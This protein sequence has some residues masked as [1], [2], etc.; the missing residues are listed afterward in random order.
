[1][2][3]K[4]IFLDFYGTLVHEDDDIIPVIC[5]EIRLSST[6]PESSVT[7][8]AAYWWKSFSALMTGSIGTAFE[9]QRALS[10]KS[11]IETVEYFD[12]RANA[13]AIIEPQFAHWANPLL[14]ED[15]QP[16][17][18]AFADR[19]RY[20]LSNIDTADVNAAIA[21]HQLDITAVLTSEDVRAYKPNPRLFEEALE[22]YGFEP[23]EVVHIGDSARSDV[24]GA[25]QAGIRTIWLNRLNK[26]LPAGIQPDYVARDLKEAEKIL[27]NEFV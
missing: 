18:E 8:I 26:R 23:G 20:V 15:T 17:L 7:E 10:L 27:R 9:T 14:F 19:P 22:R 5:E 1:M 16:F 4:A 21:I 11:L 3:P 13:E 12:S 6:K 25:Q 24:H 2:K